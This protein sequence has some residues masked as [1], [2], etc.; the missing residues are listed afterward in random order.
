MSCMKDMMAETIDHKLS[1]I[2]P[3]VFSHLGLSTVTA[4][5]GAR[6]ADSVC[7]PGISAASNTKTLPFHGSP[8]QAYQSLFG[9]VATG[10]DRKQFESQGNLFDYL[11]EDV[12]ALRKVL[13][14]TE[15]EK[16]DH[17]LEAIEALQKQRRDPCNVRPDQGWEAPVLRKYTNMTIEDRMEAH[18]ECRWSFDFWSHQCCDDPDGWL[19]F[20]VQ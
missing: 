13:S 5:M 7:Y 20:T 6:F 2:Y 18:C 15:K 4:T 11:G 3:S 10:K 19:G 14:G 9:S 8:S 12:E 17:H 16:L 1:K